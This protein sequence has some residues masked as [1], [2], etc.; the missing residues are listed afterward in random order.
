MYIHNSGCELEETACPSATPC[1]SIPYSDRLDQL[2]SILSSCRI[3]AF[4]ALRVAETL[5]RSIGVVVRTIATDILLCYYLLY[6]DVH[7]RMH[8]VLGISRSYETGRLGIDITST[9]G[10]ISSMFLVCNVV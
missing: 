8:L 9:G 10:Q 6:L 5:R 7:S 3:Y 1:Q 2:T 4:E